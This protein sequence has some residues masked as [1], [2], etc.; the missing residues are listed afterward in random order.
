MP[1]ALCSRASWV[2]PEFLYRVETVSSP[3]EHP[4]NEWELASRLSFFLGLSVPADELRQAASAGELRQPELLAR[5]V[6]R[7]T[8]EPKARRLATEFFVPDG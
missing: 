7:M 5:Q 6:R 2:P 1:C 3:T 8:A 4:L